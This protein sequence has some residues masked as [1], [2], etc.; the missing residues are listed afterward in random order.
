MA[1]DDHLATNIAVIGK[2]LPGGFTVE[3]QSPGIWEVSV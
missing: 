3:P 2:F 1:P